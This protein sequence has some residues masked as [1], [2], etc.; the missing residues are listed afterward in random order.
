MTAASKTTGA[1]TPNNLPF[2][3]TA[4]IGREKD[5]AAACALLRRDDVRLV[6]LTGPG[7]TGKTRLAVQVAGQML[8]DFKDGVF[9]VPLAA[10][11]DPTLV[12]ASIAQTLDVMESGS[13]PLVDSLKSFLRERRVLLV[14]DNFEQILEA[15]PLVADLL[16]ASSELSV[17]TTS[18]ARLR[19]RGE[20]E[21]PVPPL[22]LPER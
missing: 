18:R 5:I 13:K 17:L 8:H 14:L 15:A 19:L 4:F 16:S 2:T 12:A 1:L 6:T 7:G 20:H 10:V 11:T 9:F 3:P 22:S 21:H